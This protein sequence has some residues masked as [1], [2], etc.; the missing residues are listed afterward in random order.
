MSVVNVKNF[1]YNTNDLI[2]KGATGSV[3]KGNF[4]ITQESIL[5]TEEW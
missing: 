5:T 4:I 3:Y 2:G 1:S